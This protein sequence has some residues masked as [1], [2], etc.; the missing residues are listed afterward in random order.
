MKMSIVIYV[1]NNGVLSI[2]SMA[3]GQECH[4]DAFFCWRRN[5]STWP[6]H[7]R[8]VNTFD[9][10]MIFVFFCEL[11]SRYNKDIDNEL[12]N[13]ISFTLER[14]EMVDA[15]GLVCN[16][17]AGPCQLFSYDRRH[18]SPMLSKD[19]QRCQWGNLDCF[20]H[21]VEL[22]FNPLLFLCSCSRF[23]TLSFL[24][25]RNVLQ[26]CVGGLLFL[27]SSVLT[28]TRGVPTS[29]NKQIFLMV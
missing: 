1:E 28:S 25:F 13:S 8:N 19:F 21:R 27:I 16:E 3:W 5:K 12:T 29:P 20:V 18:F 10:F 26:I 22:D 24:F 2:I 7:K 23:I 14:E 9:F 15:H 6:K 4:F 17:P 11:I